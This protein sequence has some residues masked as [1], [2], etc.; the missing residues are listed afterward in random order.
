MVLGKV[1]IE[2]ND[3]VKI[4]IGQMVD[5]IYPMLK[6]RGYPTI[7]DEDICHELATYGDIDFTSL[8]TFKI[9]ITDYID[10]IYAKRLKWRRLFNA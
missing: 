6:E 5:I 3:M 10:R 9:I 2:R 1:Q 4:E 7:F 8:E